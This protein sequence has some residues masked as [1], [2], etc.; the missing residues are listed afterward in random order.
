MAGNIYINEDAANADIAKIRAAI[1]RLEEAQSSIKKLSNSADNMTGQTGEA[2]KEKCA[3][4]DSQI[5]SLT[6]NLNY[7]IR[8]IKGA[9]Q[10]YQQKDAEMAS[11]IKSGG[12]V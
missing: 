10:E 1:A 11:A 8:L 7:T 3:T 4:L 9:I 6:G 12:G 5:K 2:I